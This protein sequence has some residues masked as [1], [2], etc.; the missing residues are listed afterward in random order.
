MDETVVELRFPLT[1]PA[2]WREAGYPDR[3]ENVYCDGIESLPDGM[4]RLFDD[5]VGKP[6]VVPN[7]NVV[8]IGH[9]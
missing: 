2:A 6:W 5:D 4:Y 8:S 1:P 7:R 3:V 9:S